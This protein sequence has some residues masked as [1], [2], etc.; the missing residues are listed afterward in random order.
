MN[1]K[2]LGRLGGKSRSAAKASAARM[3]GKRGGR[4]TKS[5][6]FARRVLAEQARLRPLLPEVDPDDLSL[7]LASLLCPVER[8][9]FFLLPL[10]G[11]GFAF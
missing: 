6:A 2:K 4:P 8:R 7:I 10:E 5:D 1:A 3:N 9:M 11:G